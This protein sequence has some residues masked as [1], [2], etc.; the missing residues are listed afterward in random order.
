MEEEGSGADTIMQNLRKFNAADTKMKEAVCAF[1]ASHLL[2]KEEVQPIDRVF[3]A[4]DTQRDDKIRRYELKQAYYKVYNKLITDKEL[5]KIMKRIDLDGNDEFSY[6]EFCMAAVNKK[7]LLSH[8]R[9]KL[10]FD[11][12]DKQS[13]GYVTYDELR[14]AFRFV[15][16]DMSYLNK[17]IKQVDDGKISFAEFVV[18]MTNIDLHE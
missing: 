5:D 13:K 4:L 1:I 11:L 18:M 16:M 10:A 14:E 6:S 17:I 7:D 2:T 3:Q 9:L 12:F 15:D 8:S